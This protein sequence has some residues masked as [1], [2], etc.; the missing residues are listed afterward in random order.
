MSYRTQ[1]AQA[2]R[3]AVANQMILPS[4][5]AATE[6][7]ALRAVEMT[8]SAY[9]C[10]VTIRMTHREQDARQAACIRRMSD[11]QFDR[12]AMGL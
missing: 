11:A 10:G 8:G 7:D 2:A 12:Y 3:L 1:I 6:A 4:E 5:V 9:I